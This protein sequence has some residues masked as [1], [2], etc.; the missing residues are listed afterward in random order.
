MMVVG[1]IAC[2]LVEITN[3]VC[4]LENQ[5]N[6]NVTLTLW[7]PQSI[8]RAESEN[9]YQL[10]Q[11]HRVST[12]RDHSAVLI[13]LMDLVHNLCTVLCTWMDH[14][15]GNDLKPGNN[16]SKLETRDTT[17]YIQECV[18]FPSS[19]LL[20]VTQLY[21]GLWCVIRYYTIE[22]S[23]YM[24]LWFQLGSYGALQTAI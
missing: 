24:M 19:A 15:T 11:N 4:R 9:L 17:T 23:G 14:I 3:K 10:W 12:W 20:Q 5:K 18:L 2:W 21:L 7:T 13:I 8:G 22:I 6:W 16:I 1:F